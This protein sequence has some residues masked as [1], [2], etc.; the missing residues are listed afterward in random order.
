MNQS[1]CA[2]NVKLSHAICQEVARHDILI[3]P[4]PST[5]I[6]YT[7]T[8]KHHTLSL[9]FTVVSIVR[10]RCDDNMFV[11]QDDYVC[12][13]AL[14]FS[15]SIYNCTI[16]VQY[17]CP[18]TLYECALVCEW[19]C[20]IQIAHVRVIYLA[21]IVFIIR[22]YD[23]GC[24]TRARNALVQNNK[25]SFSYHFGALW[26]RFMSKET[27]THNFPP[28][29]PASH[30]NKTIAYQMS[31]YAVHMLSEL[32]TW[33]PFRRIQMKDNPNAARRT[34]SR[35]VDVGR[36]CCYWQRVLPMY[37]LTTFDIYLFNIC[38]CWI[39]SKRPNWHSNTPHTHRQTGRNA[40]VYFWN[41]IF[42]PAR[43]SVWWVFH[44]FTYC[45]IVD[46]PQHKIF[47]DK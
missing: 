23:C 43:V 28:F 16:R 26:C 22:D 19:V 13:H 41:A 46:D 24:G 20:E 2:V 38:S 36:W 29:S 6:S 18:C 34:Q 40:R 5:F 17:M 11:V 21:K 1:V 31:R 4:L 7:Q 15:N 47:L 3:L 27:L 33:K 39:W 9:S 8:H 25:V 42:S 30:C 32:G 37:E 45:Y 14:F 35:C 10:V 44:I 12:A